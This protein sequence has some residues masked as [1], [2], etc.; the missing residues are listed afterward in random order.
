MWI[1]VEDR[2]PGISKF[3]LVVCKTGGEIFTIRTPLLAIFLN[4]EWKCCG[5]DF[6]PVDLPINGEVT[7]WMELPALPEEKD[8]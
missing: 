2:L 4:G 5:S 8:E 7:H 3:K 1:S 6:G